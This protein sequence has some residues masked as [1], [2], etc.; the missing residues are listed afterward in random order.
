MDFCIKRGEEKIFLS[1]DLFDIMYN[2]RKRIKFFFFYQMN[3]I[4]AELPE[5]CRKNVIDLNEK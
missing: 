1:L 4:A 3:D 2:L 5:D